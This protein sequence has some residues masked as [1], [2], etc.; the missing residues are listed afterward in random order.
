MRALLLGAAGKG[1]TLLIHIARPA[2]AHPLRAAAVGDQDVAL[3]AD[4][5]LRILAQIFG[6]LEALAAWL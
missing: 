2:A 4:I 3:V 5:A 6:D 1:I